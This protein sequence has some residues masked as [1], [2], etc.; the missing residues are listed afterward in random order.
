MPFTNVWQRYKTWFAH[1]NIY[2]PPPPIEVGLKKLQGGG[3]GLL[4]YL[5]Y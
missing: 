1:V 4:I 3:G 5:Y 2:S